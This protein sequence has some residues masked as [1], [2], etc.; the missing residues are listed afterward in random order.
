MTYHDSIVVPYA[1]A[2]CLNSMACVLPIDLV[3]DET[4]STS[5]VGDTAASSDSASGTGTTP[6]PAEINICEEFARDPGPTPSSTIVVRNDTDEVIF[7]GSD[8][9]DDDRCWYPVF[10][11]TPDV[12]G[13][14]WLGNGCDMRCDEVFSGDC[15]ACDYCEGVSLIR[16][17]PGDQWELVWS[18]TVVESRDVPVACVTDDLC[19]SFCEQHTVAPSAEYRVRAIARNECFSENPSD[20]SCGNGEQSCT[21]NV[22]ESAPATLEATAVLTHPGITELVFE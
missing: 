5:E 7:V 20:C 3:D 16:L 9:N 6:N 8:P 10:I 18:G 21:V 4:D 17:E 12:F 19:F 15:G 13:V 22:E 11:T 1:L 2:L 14:N